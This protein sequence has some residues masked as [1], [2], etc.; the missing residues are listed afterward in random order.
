ML[1]CDLSVLGQRSLR[2]VPARKAAMS[3]SASAGSAQAV[4][5]EHLGPQDVG[6]PGGVEPLVDRGRRCGWAHRATTQGPGH[7]AQ[8]LDHHRFSYSGYYRLAF[9]DVATKS[10]VHIQETDDDSA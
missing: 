5:R 6:R 4:A 2:G 10:P 9:L 1:L 8:K 7:E 3:V